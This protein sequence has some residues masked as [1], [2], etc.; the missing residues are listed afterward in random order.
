M[1]TLSM[2]PNTYPDPYYTI[3]K[4]RKVTR[5]IDK[6]GSVRIDKIPLSMINNMLLR[7]LRDCEQFSDDDVFSSF[8][9]SLFY[10]FSVFHHIYLNEYRE[11]DF[12][13]LDNC[14]RAFIDFQ[15]YL[16]EI[17]TVYKRHGSWIRGKL[18]RLKLFD[19]KNTTDNIDAIVRW[20]HEVEAGRI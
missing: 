8:D 19:L 7:S 12:A 20:K 3:R 13:S 10:C 14:Q 11:Y 9:S 18:P 6:H 4:I 17:V 16:W 1:P 15:R 2:L 5:Q